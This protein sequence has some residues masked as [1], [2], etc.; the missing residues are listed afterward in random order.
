[1][2]KQLFEIKNLQVKT[3]KK[4]I[5]KGITL[6]VKPGE[7]HALMGPN[8]SGKTSLAL[9]LAG[10]PAYEVVK[11]KAKPSQVIL[12]GKDL[13]NLSPDKRAKAGLF[14]AFQQPVEI[15]GVRVNQFLRQ[16]HQ[17][18]FG[19]KSRKKYPS[20]YKFY[21]YLSGVAEKIGV[22]QSLLGRNLNEGFSGGEKKQLEM[23]QLVVLKP[24]YAVLDETDSGL[25]VDAL[26]IVAKAVEIVRTKHKTGI[27][28]ITH[29]LR[30]LEHVQPE[31]VHLLVDGQITE[32]GDYELAKRLEKKGYKK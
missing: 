9:S 4:L 5:L 24:K 11:D 7:I 21:E 31:F 14:L 30:I 25:D 16:A 32:N 12:D 6:R 19:E 2:K 20:A 17:T 27:L 3:G 18:L 28:I 15:P 23:L 29:Y 8:G 10:H 1:M 13:L 22:D 26:K